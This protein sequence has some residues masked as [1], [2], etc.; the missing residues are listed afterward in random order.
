[1]EGRLL[2]RGGDAHEPGDLETE[3]TALGD[4]SVGLRGK[5]AR[6]LRLLACIDFGEETGT[7]A[8]PDHL[9]GERLSELRPVER[10]DDV[11]E[12]H[13]FLHLVGLKGSDEMELEARCGSLEGGVFVRRLLN[14]VFP[15][16]LLS[17]G[18]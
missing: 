17:G 2:V 9:A 8:L 3:A 6:L 18:N 1:M 15:E 11:E 10:L 16:L 5:H 14:P 12:R 13:R 7:A 4:E